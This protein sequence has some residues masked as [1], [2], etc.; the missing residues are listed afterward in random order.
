MENFGD[1][2]IDRNRKVRKKSVEVNE[3]TKNNNMH[4]LWWK[5]KI[6]HDLYSMLA[7]AMGL[8]IRKVVGLR[9]EMLRGSVF[10]AV[11]LLFSQFLGCPTWTFLFYNRNWLVGPSCVQK[12]SLMPDPH[13]A[14][15]ISLRPLSGHSPLL[16]TLRAITKKHT[17]E[18]G[19]SL[20]SLQSSQ[21]YLKY[22]LWL[23]WVI[24]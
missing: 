18:H 21:T 11:N 10:N 19:A 3:E 20:W 8:E 17:V 5:E 9:M 14:K 6:P 1:K 4:I 15:W 7:I 22:W 2:I 23:A 12:V 16:S 24:C 13:W